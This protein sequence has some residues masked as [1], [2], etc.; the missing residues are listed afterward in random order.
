MKTRTPLACVALV[1][2][3]VLAIVPAS[4]FAVAPAQGADVDDA[5]ILAL[6]AASEYVASSTGHGTPTVV[7]DD[8]SGD[9]SGD[10]TGD[11]PIDVEV[12]ESVPYTSQGFTLYLPDNWNVDTSDDI[13][14]ITADDFATGLTMQF[15]SFG[16]DVPGLFMIPVFESIAP[17][18]AA[19][20]GEGAETG[21]LERL[22]INDTLPA[23]RMTFTGVEDSF[24]D[25]T[26]DGVIWVLATGDKG[27]GVY[28]GSSAET[29]PTL[30][31]IVDEAVAGIEIDPENITLQQAGDEPLELFNVEGTYSVQIPPGWY[32]TTTDDEDLGIVFSDPD[33][34]FVGAG[35]LSPETEANDP[36][37][38]TL[39]EATAGALDEETS[40][41]IIEAILEEMDM[42]GDGSVIIDDSQTT[43]FPSAA[44]GMLGI[45]RVAGEAPIDDDIIL[46]VVL[47]LS[48][49]TDRAGA[50]IFMGNTE[51]VFASEEAILQVI[52]SLQIAE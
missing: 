16:E 51:S 50:F 35:G 14:N 30:G 12:G 42:A 31:P 46:P 25:S 49:F 8:D 45:V 4:V 48:V 27:Y 37:L 40:A 13:A 33:V 26:M 21:E 20:L 34:T 1:L 38:Q 7:S 23:L 47:Y 15:E 2:M 43:V 24:S 44:N 18:F 36:M 29:W 9:D 5:T 17:M 19:E 41:Q 52:E 28:A 10:D 39:I 22:L 6:I 3:L 32:A 11:I